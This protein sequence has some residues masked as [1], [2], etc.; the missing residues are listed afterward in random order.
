MDHGKDSTIIIRMDKNVMYMID[1]AKMRYTEMPIDSKGDIFSSAISASG[2]SGEEQAEAK[3]MMEGFAKMMK[4]KV[5]VKAIGETQKI[6]NWNCK[7]Y[8]MTMSMMGTDVKSTQELLEVS[9][10]SAPGGTYDVPSGYK[11][12]N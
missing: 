11:K 9:D 8:I 1:H 5:T 6:N 2:L 12:Q 4:P 7:K 3:K 10:K